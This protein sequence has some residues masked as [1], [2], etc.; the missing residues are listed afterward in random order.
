MTR[1]FP[2]VGI[3][4]GTPSSQTQLW[5][6]TS[7]EVSGWGACRPHGEPATDRVERHVDGVFFGA[8]SG[9]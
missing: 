8:L 4:A 1:S 9:F 7:R 3:S 6:S 5:C 2:N